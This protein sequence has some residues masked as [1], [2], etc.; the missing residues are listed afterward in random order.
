MN[1]F[2]PLTMR[3][4]LMNWHQWLTEEL[5]VFGTLYQVG[6]IA[7]LLFLALPLAAWLR[8]R[9]VSP[10]L[11]QYLADEAKLVAYERKIARVGRPL[12]A[13]VLLGLAYLIAEKS[14]LSR[15]LIFVAFELTLAWVLIRLLTDFLFGEYWAKIVALIVWTVVALDLA[16]FLHPIISILDQVGLSLEGKRITPWLLIKAGVLL[17][18]FFALANKIITL[19]EDRIKKSEQLTPSVQ[20]LLIKISKTALYALALLIALDSVGID[21]QYLLVFSGAV[22]LGLGLG[23]QK[24]VSNLVS[25]YILLMDNSIRPGDVIELEGVYGWIESL[26]ARYISMITRDGTAYLVPN[27]QLMSNM[28]INWSFSE[29]GLRLKIPVGISYGSDVRRAMELMEEVAQKFP[30]VLKDPP[31]GAR[32][33][34]FGDSAV[35]LELRA[36]IRDPQRGVVN[37]KSDIQLGIWDAFHENGIEFPFPQQDLHLKTVPDL[38]VK[39]GEE[40]NAKI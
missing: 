21:F 19:F 3:D 30:R 27:E 33:V 7:G 36:W 18:L 23:L 39:L 1:D 17:V 9:V 28:V 35:D 38:R 29:K 2:L 12:M 5:F 20:V 40:P 10:R 14:Q 25:G 34:S 15:Q 8:R 13:T 31:P 4:F 22:G 24:V 26:N 16:R 11:R 6:V 37:I 32:L